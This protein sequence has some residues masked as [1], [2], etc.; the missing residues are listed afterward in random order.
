MITSEVEYERITFSLPSSLNKTLNSF[1]KEIN[2]SKSEII[3]L[4]IESYLD[5]Q[6][7]IKMQKAV[8]MMAKEYEEDSD[9]IELI[10]L[11][12]ENFQRNKVRLG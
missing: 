6:E 4:A 10:S 1:K 2:S 7:K 5:N 11:D 3:K 12:S 9:L 8:E